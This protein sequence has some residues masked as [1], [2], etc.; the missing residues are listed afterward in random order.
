MVTADV[1][2]ATKHD[3]KVVFPVAALLI[4]L[5]L[6]AL[7]RSAVA[8]LTLLVGVGLGFAATL[9]ASVIA[10]QGIKGDPGLVSMLPMIVYLFVVAVGTDYN[11]LLTSR[12]REEVSEGVAPREAAA[13]AVEHAGPT[14]ASAGIILAGTFGS[15]MLAGVDLLS[16][17]GFAVAIGIILVAILMA[18]VLIPSLATLIGER[19]WW[20]GHAQPARTKTDVPATPHRRP[21]PTIEPAPARDG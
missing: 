13:R 20:P 7:L 12:L 9:G 15:L 18:S 10:F 1:R 11:I 19:L 14:V 17:M 16:E 2:T 6:G 21:R 3:Y 4:L 5:I 8:P